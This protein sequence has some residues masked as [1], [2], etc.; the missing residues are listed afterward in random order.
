VDNGRQLTDQVG[1]HQVFKDTLD[2]GI[3]L[4][5]MSFMQR[6][7]QSVLVGEILIDRAYAKPST[8]GNQIGIGI[9]TLA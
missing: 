8:L 9:A 4:Q 1:G 3:H 5:G 2:F 7:D 6:A